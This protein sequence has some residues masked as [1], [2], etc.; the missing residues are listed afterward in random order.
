MKMQQESSRLLSTLP[1]LF[2]FIKIQELMSY[3]MTKTTAEHF[4]T[5]INFVVITF[6]AVQLRDINI[7]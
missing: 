6:L 3:A 7:V 4:F 1:F 5:P 2:L